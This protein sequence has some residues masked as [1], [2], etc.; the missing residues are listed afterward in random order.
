MGRNK[1]NKDRQ[2]MARAE[3]ATIVITFFNCTLRRRKMKIFRMKKNPIT[4][5][6]KAVAQQG[7][8]MDADDQCQR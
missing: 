1:T 2:N 6:R 8:R 7:L 4:V 5:K 3:S